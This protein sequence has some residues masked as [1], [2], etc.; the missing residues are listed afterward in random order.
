MIMSEEGTTV[1]DTA[2]KRGPG[3]PPKRVPQTMTEANW[4][5][6]PGEHHVMESLKI[7]EMPKPEP[8]SE[9][10]NEKDKLINE[11]KIALEPFT[12]IPFEPNSPPEKI[13]FRL[14][15]HTGTVDIT[16]GN[17]I[18]AKTILGM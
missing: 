4:Q 9:Q 2:P 15:R 12:K 10:E 18:K 7:S 13:L 17:I 6:I 16:N 5:Q 3:R 14:A 11:L 8:P 1:T